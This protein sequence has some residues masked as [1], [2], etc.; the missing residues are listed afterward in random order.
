[1]KVEIFDPSGRNI[2]DTGEPGELVCTR[3]H[4]SLP[5]YFWGDEGDKKLRAAYFD[6][7]PGTWRQGDFIVK[8]PKTQGFMILGRRFVLY[9]FYRL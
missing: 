4:P 7:Y 1:M 3:P 9:S 8:N 2:E 6:T 5:I